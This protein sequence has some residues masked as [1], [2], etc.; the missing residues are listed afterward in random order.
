MINKLLIDLNKRGRVSINVQVADAFDTHSFAT[1][2]GVGATTINPYLAIDSIYDRLQ[3]NILQDLSFDEAVKRYIKAINSSLL[4]IMAKMGISVIGSYRGGGNFETVGLSRTIINEFFPNVVSKISGIGL[5][6]IEEKITKIHMQAFDNDFDNIMLPIGGLY[7]SRHNEETH[8]YQAT[9]IH[10]LQNAV[11]VNSYDKYKKYTKGIYNLPPINIRDL[12]DFKDK[13]S[14]IDINE[15]ES[16]ENI[17]HRFGTGSMSHGALSK[18]AHETLAIAMNRIKGA[19]CSGESRERFKS[20]KNGD[21][22]N[23]RV[24]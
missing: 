22:A 21:S 14:P 11:F 17:L 7:R 15:V 18:E 3:K 10:L 12:I 24:K 16:I 9:L 23:S 19:S 1:L 13:R 6:G 4:K 5:A 2:I 20:I 8:Q